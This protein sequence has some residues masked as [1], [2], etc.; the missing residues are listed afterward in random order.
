MNNPLDPREIARN[1]GEAR[2]ER[3]PTNIVVR[4][5]DFTDLI[6][7]GKAWIQQQNPGKNVLDCSVEDGEWAICETPIGVFALSKEGIGPSEP[8]DNDENRVRIGIYGEYGKTRGI[9]GREIGSESFDGFPAA[10]IRLGLDQMMGM[11]TGGRTWY[12]TG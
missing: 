11:A 4:L 5:I 12:E 6:E 7:Q 2:R 1:L 10:T 8:L 3:K 9:G